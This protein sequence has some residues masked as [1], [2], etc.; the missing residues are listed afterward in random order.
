[1]WDVLAYVAFVVVIIACLRFV[2]RDLPLDDVPR[3]SPPTD[4]ATSDR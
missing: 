2:T 4:P 1:M 3:T